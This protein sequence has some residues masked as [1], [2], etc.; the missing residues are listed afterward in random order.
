MHLRKFK[1]GIYGKIPVIEPP[2]NFCARLWWYIEA[3]FLPH[4]EYPTEVGVV[5]WVTTEGHIEFEQATGIWKLYFT[6]E[7]AKD[8]LEE[9]FHL[10]F[11]LSLG[12]RCY[13]GFTY[14]DGIQFL[15]E[16]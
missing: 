1:L 11:S 15:P 16:E 10:R 14:P 9:G 5:K 6:K 2:A 12:N 4:D 7:Q 3:G 8:L 13:H